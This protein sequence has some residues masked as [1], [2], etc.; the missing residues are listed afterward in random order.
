MVG[1]EI[2]KIPVLPCQH[3]LTSV[4]NFIKRKDKDREELSD[5]QNAG[6]RVCVSVFLKLHELF[7][8]EPANS[9][10]TFGLHFTSI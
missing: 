7:T 6:I 8:R 5:R 2:E 9:H 3:S 4:A 1:N 10:N